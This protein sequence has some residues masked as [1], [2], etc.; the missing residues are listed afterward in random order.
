[1]V[2][3]DDIVTSRNNDY[4]AVYYNDYDDYFHCEG[5]HCNYFYFYKFDD[6]TYDNDNGSFSKREREGFDE[7]R[8]IFVITNARFRVAFCRVNDAHCF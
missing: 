7:E 3:S 5:F 8:A 2:L 4:D 1:M 6:L